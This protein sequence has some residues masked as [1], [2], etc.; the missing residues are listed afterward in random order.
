MT[1]K[2]LLCNNIIKDTENYSWRHNDKPAKIDNEII[3]GTYV[4][5]NTFIDS[6]D[7][8]NIIDISF[9]MPD[10]NKDYI[11]VGESYD[12]PFFQNIRTTFKSYSEVEVAEIYIGSVK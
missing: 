9:A 4:E 3:N 8:V 10:P 2:C 1:K 7:Y 11:A 12:D 6:N 5:F